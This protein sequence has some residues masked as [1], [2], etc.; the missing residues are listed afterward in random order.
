M[1]GGHVFERNITKYAHPALFVELLKLIAHGHIFERLP[2]V[3]APLC[4]NITKGATSDTFNV[5][6]WKLSV[7]V[8]V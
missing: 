6:V 2:T 7:D 5:L 1:R 8:G 3:S 4:H